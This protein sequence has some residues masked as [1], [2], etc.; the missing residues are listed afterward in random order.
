MISASIIQYCTNCNKDH[1]FVSDWPYCDPHQPHGFLTYT[2]M[3][4]R[5]QFCGGLPGHALHNEELR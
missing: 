3:E 5:C 4:G 2:G 1:K